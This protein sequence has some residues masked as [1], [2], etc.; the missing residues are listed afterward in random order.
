MKFYFEQFSWDDMVKDV[1]EQH[2]Q[3]QVKHRII[4]EGKTNTL[5]TGDR[6]RLEQVLN[7]LLSNAIKYSPDAEDVTVRSEIADGEV[8][9]SVVDSG[10]GIPK[11][12]MEHVF[13]RFYRVEDSGMSFSGLGLGLYISAEIIKR[14]DGAI[15]V[16][17]N[18]DKGSVFWITLPIE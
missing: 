18:K 4:L 11:D 7:N 2:Q 6:N 15:G 12:K 8:K 5:V 14:H 3:A 17:S 10:I 13:E 16:E 9:L 1:V